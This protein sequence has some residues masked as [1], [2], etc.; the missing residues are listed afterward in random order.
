MTTKKPIEKKPVEKQA[1][2]PASKP[3]YADTKKPGVPVE[4]PYTHS[5]PRRKT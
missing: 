2:E 4:T 5:D 3:A 1:E